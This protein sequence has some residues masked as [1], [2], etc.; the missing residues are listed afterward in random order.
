MKERIPFSDNE[1]KQAA[2]QVIAA[3]ADQS[4]QT[5]ETPAYTPEFLDRMDEMI[6]Q[7]N[8][9][10]HRRRRVYSSVAA[11]LAL[12]LLIVGLMMSGNVE[13]RAAEKEWGYE[14]IVADRLFYRFTGEPRYNAANPLPHYELG[15]LPEGFV[16]SDNL[17]LF[18][19]WRGIVFAAY[20]NTETGSKIIFSYFDMCE[21]HGVEIMDSTPNAPAP[22]YQL[23]K[24]GGTNMYYHDMADPG[25]PYRA[26]VMW[27]N[28]EQNIFFMLDCRIDDETLFRMAE[29]VVEV[30]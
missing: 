28:M 23:V 19:E 12:V 26:G 8:R 20:I 29:S 9:N 5:E 1:I 13:T 24:V 25:E 4:D 21:G 27:V 17:S 3:M 7:V 14:E 6:G 18:Q 10:Q 11:A 22:A 15:W 16:L 2:D 30:P